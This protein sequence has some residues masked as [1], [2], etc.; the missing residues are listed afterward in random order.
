MSSLILKNVNYSVKG[1]S[2][3]NISF[4]VP[5]GCITSLVG[6]DGAGKTTLIHIIANNLI[7]KSGTILYDGRLFWEDEAGIK[8][9][10]GFV[11][12]VVCFN[13][14]LTPKQFL[15]RAKS[16][17]QDFDSDLF[18][19]YMDKF[20]LSYKHAIVKFLPDM[21]RKFELI[22]ALS[23]HPQILILD[24]P[25]MDLEPADRNTIWDILQDFVKDGQNSVL[26]TSSSTEDFDQIVDYLIFID[27]GKIVKADYNSKN[28]TE[29]DRKALINEKNILVK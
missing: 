7:R 26:I 4:E 5:K 28:N 23:R 21:K 3:E 20:D 22:V 16:C 25:T 9:K 15:K 10:L 12:D 2:L 6:P 19:S 29:T 1:F 17:I 11:Y 24:E 18:C 8:R 13:T 27:K 14:Q